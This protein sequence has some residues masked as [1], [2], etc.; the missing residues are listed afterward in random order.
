MMLVSLISYVDRQTLA[1]LSPTIL[2]QTGLTV[3]QY[4]YIISAF[5]VAYSLGNPVWGRILDRVGLRSGM[6]ASV[7]MWTAASAAHG[8]AT[9]LWSFAAARAALG[10]GEGATFPGGLRAAVQSLPM[11]LRSRGIAVSYSG[12]SLGALLTPLIVGPVAAAWG[13]RAAFFATGLVGLAWLA[14]WA[15]V[16]RRPDM[17]RRASATVEVAVARPRWTDPRVWSFMC[18]YALGG[19]PLGFV[20]YQTAIYLNR[21]LGATQSDISR[22]LWVPP[23]GWEAGYFF[24]GWLADRTLQRVPSRTRAY[25]ALFA[26]CTLLSLPLAAVPHL[27]PLLVPTL[28]LLFLAMFAAAGF[29]IISMSYSTHVYSAGD[30]GL[31]AG[32]GA[33]SW[34]ALVAVSM[35]LFGRL[36]D[37]RG[38]GWAFL[39]ASLAPVLGY[40]IWWAVNRDR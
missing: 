9:G 4:G 32:L 11:H 35:P 33:G 17:A 14:L 27:P 6:A 15:F 21:V 2:A 39:A 29:I 19:L 37:A 40:A 18:A 16:S 22:V 13:W 34:S 3:E 8:F 23:L 20:L 24:W 1:L 12:G 26:L 5:S 31:V 25:R 7:S 28:A 30:S 10:F 38:Y 36:F